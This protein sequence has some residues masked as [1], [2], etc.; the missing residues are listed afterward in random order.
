MVRLGIGRQKTKACIP[1]EFCRNV[2]L[3][4]C[5]TAY[6]RSPNEKIHNKA[7]CKHNATLILPFLK[8]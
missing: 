1:T 2:I 6:D 5:E 7:D 3:R 4:S 8:P